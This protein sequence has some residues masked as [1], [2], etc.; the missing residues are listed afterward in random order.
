MNNNEIP[1]YFYT[2]GRGLVFNSKNELLVVS[3]DNMKWH[4]PGGTLE[5]NITIES[6]VKKE[7]YEETGINVKV[8]DF[9]FITQ[10]TYQKDDGYFQNK[11]IDFK[12]ITKAFAIYYH[13]EI[14]GP[15]ELDPKWVDIGHGVI[16]HRKFVSE[17]EFKSMQNFVIKGL[18]KM[19]FSEIKNS[20]S[21]EIKS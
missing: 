4:I 17:S 19:T 2:V 5:E 9:A 8:G 6:L 15:E 21:I 12:H 18:Q 13:C 3:G 11:Y 10:I 7:I 16:K 1:L 20:K 14:D